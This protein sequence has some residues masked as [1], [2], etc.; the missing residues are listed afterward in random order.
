MEL[1]SAQLS[2]G[3][4]VVESLWGQPLDWEGTVGHLLV[5]G[6]GVEIFRETKVTDLYHIL[7]AQEDVSQGQVA[8][9]NLEIVLP[10]E[11]ER[12]M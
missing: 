4:P 6:V 10:S 12:R 9:E 7:Q 2:S 1:S 3:S 8:V 11:S 5:V